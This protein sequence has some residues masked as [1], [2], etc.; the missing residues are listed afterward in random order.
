M[1]TARIF[2]LV[3][4]LALGSANAH[5]FVREFDRTGIADEWVKN[6]TVMIHL[7]LTTARHNFSDCSLSYN[8]IAE[9]ALNSWNQVLVHMQFAVD[10]G[11]ILPPS[12]KDANTSVTMSDTFYGQTFGNNVLAVTL[13]T[14]RDGH[15]I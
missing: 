12:A 6:R 5:A 1:F 10:R 15:M 11:S 14:P 2:L 7:S 4:A 9:D 13:V 3:A 8:A